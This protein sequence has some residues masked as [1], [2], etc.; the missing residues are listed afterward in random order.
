MSA[1]PTREVVLSAFDRMRLLDIDDFLPVITGAE[2]KGDGYG[3]LP[4]T[5][6][7]GVSS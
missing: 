2:R 4:I 5:N 3:V 1:R 6:K 7:A